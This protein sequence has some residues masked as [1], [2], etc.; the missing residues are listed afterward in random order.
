[1]T[2]TEIADLIDLTD[3]ELAA[4]DTRPPRE[5]LVVYPYLDELPEHDRE[6]MIIAALRGLVTR[7]HVELPGPTELAGLLSAT[8]HTAQVPV[9]LNPGLQQLLNFRR[10]AE[11]IVAAQRTTNG[12]TEFQYVYRLPDEVALTENVSAG[13]VHHFQVVDNAQIPAALG[14]YTNPE[15]VP[16]ATGRAITFDPS[17]AHGPLDDLQCFAEILVRDAHHN[18]PPPLLGIFC[19]DNALYISRTRFAGHEPIVLTAQDAT[20][21]VAT[22]GA[23]IDD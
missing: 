19:T 5:R 23:F 3:E 18:E 14:D 1:M 2:G 6:V 15:A 17:A 13:G 11:R 8:S 16:G 7:G 20:Q 12:S 21:L 22:I 4:I 10:Q 9:R